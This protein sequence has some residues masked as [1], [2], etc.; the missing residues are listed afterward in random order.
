MS[1]SG[2]GGAVGLCDH[3][4]VP[5]TAQR[6]LGLAG[7]VA[8]CAGGYQVGALPGRA[9]RDSLPGLAQAPGIAACLMGLVA[10]TVAWWSLRRAPLTGR[11]V[12]VTAGLWALPLLVA[13][14]LASRDIY[15]YA[16]HGAD[17]PCRWLDSV[18]PIWRGA[19][20]PYG[21]LF[22][23]LEDLA[24][25]TGRIA[26]AVGVFRAVALAGIG[27]AAWYGRSLAI[28]CGV[29]PARAGWLALLSPLVLLHAVAGA[30]ND[31]LM[32]GLVLAGFAFAGSRRGLAAWVALGLAAAVKVTAVLA[33]PFA[34]VALG[35]RLTG[36]FSE[37]SRTTHRSARGV[38]MAGAAAVVY[39]GLSLMAG[40]GDI[41]GA[42]GRT[43]DLAQWT[44]VPTA[45]GM[46]IGYPLRAAGLDGGY[47]AAIAVARGIGLAAL[48]ALVAAVW[49]RA[50]RD[51]RPR[52]VVSA[53]GIAFAGLALLGPVFYPWYALTPLALLAVSTV[54]ER[55]RAW[56]GVASAVLAF[57]VL[58]N[59]AGL[60]P[61]TKAPGAV[62]VTAAVVAAAVR[63]VR[64]PA[65]ARG[66]SLRSRRPPIG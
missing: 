47:D 30:H 46:T 39:A 40:G 45:V 37:S 1:G 52:R 22:T 34:L 42:L 2:G 60:A 58:P 50:W 4:C 6:Y 20:S 41:L 59:G 64:M 56:L 24:G 15:A 17:P 18:P 33:L 54:D 12:L 28:A 49:W 31:A 25:E 19:T 8:L 7:S 10:L 38:A 65:P 9:D 36:G 62:A 55:I 63:W 21:P 57:L 23:L 32:T 43:S 14:P 48:A 29:E 26:V 53:A 11:W 3:P 66:A 35:P 27:L 44:S 61:R 16:C 51:P 5:L 13:P